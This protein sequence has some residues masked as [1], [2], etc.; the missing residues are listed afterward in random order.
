M[1]SQPYLAALARLRA[2]FA[3]YVAS[4]AVL[5]RS[6]ELKDKTR[7][8]ARAAFDAGVPFP[9]LC[10]ELGRVA[11]EALEHDRLAALAVGRAMVRWAAPV[12][13]APAA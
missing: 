2:T 3:P 7:D 6:L 13:G 10:A 5:V 8:T 9:A 1:L 4:P 12:Y 11:V